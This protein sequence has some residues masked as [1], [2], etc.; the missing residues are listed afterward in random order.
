M[1]K[2]YYDDETPDYLSY[3][4]DEEEKAFVDRDKILEFLNDRKNRGKWHRIPASFMKAVPIEEN[5]IMASVIID[6]VENYRGLHRGIEETM[7]SGFSLLVSFY[8]EDEKKTVTYPLRTSAVIPLLERTYLVCPAMTGRWRNPKQKAE[9]I[10][11]VLQN[12]YLDKKEVQIYVSDYK[13]STIPSSKYVVINADELLTNTESAMEF[14]FGSVE[15]L[16]GTVSHLMTVANYR[17]GSDEDRQEMLN[18]LSTLGCSASEIDLRI[19]LTT[20]DVEESACRLYSLMVI[21]G[22]ELP[23]GKPLVMPHIGSCA[24]DLWFNEVCTKVSN[25]LKETIEAIDKLAAIRINN[26]GP[27]LK[28]AAFRLGLSQT[29]TVKIVEEFEAMYTKCTA[30]DIYQFLHEISA[31]NSDKMS[32]LKKLQATENIA[33]VLTWSHDDFKKMDVPEYVWGTKFEK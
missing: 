4:K 30:L 33:R 25:I 22:L 29:A 15:F 31:L 3:L 11:N 12:S 16:D 21:D 32:A 28:F 9:D 1:C 8:D 7:N 20:S 24:I 18:H 17:Y 26:P 14:A 6:S 13:I 10:N 27:A 19:R 23:L 5:P 2:N